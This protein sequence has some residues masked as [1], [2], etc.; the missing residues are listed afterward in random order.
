MTKKVTSLKKSDI[1]K[2]D[3]RHSNIMKKEKVK[4]TWISL[5]VLSVVFSCFIL[6]ATAQNSVQPITKIYRVGIFAPLYLDT[7]FTNTGTIRF[8]DAIPKFITPGLEFVHGAQIA[9]DSMKLASENVE[10]FIYDTKSYTKTIPRLISDK[11]LDTLDIIIGSVKDV[12]FRQLADF[13]LSKNIPFI[14]ATYPNDGGV[15]ANPSLVIVNSTLK[16][17][18]EAIFSYLVQSHGTDRIFLCRQKGPQEDKVAAYFRMINVQD[19][20]PLL[21]IQTLNFDSIVSPGLLKNRLDSNRQIVII[22]GS[23]DETFATKLT[24]ACYELHES[25]PITLIGMPNWDSFKELM[26]KDALVDFPVFF[27][28]PYFNT[29]WDDYSKMVNA[30][31]A[32]KYKARATDMVFKGFECTWLFTKLLTKFPGNVISHIN[33]KS[34]KLITDY[35]FRPVMLKKDAP[36]TDYYENKHLYFVRIMNGTIAKAW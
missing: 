12:D 13:A 31:Y 11:K 7:I 17:H 28:S 2:S 34:F 36:V 20:K 8:T 10:A 14:S 1:N 4:K 25:Y 18:C 23:L 29:K 15:T 3:I 16:A 22:G 21:D 9:L 19:G 26:N 32:K 6:P 30:V 27:T 35:N 24:M 5:V 33:D